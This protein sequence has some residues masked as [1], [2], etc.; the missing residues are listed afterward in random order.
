VIDVMMNVI[1]FAVHLAET[2]V[3][4]EIALENRYSYRLARP[5]TGRKTDSGRYAAISMGNTANAQSVNLPRPAT[6]MGLKKPKRSEIKESRGL[7]RNDK[8]LGLCNLSLRCRSIGDFLI[9]GAFRFIVGSRA[10]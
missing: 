3:E 6:P 10:F 8:P 9:S 2:P 1:P 4:E 7:V 5:A